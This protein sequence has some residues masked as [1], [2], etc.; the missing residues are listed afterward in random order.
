M[1]LPI[2]M[3]SDSVDLSNRFRFTTTVA[4][5][6]SG[7]SE[8]IIGTVTAIPD[9]VVNAGVLLFGWAAFTVGTSGT[10][11]QLQIRRTNVAGTVV[12]N[13]GATTAAAASLQE[14]SAQS[15]DTGPTIPGQVYVLTLTITAGAAA[16][17]VSALQLVAIVI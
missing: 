16:S 13:S 15:F 11:A 17:T 4:A 8:T 1:P 12:A 3:A 7:A 9:L 14:R 6:P 5:S 2:R 10:A